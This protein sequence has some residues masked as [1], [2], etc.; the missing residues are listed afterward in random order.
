MLTTG[1]RINKQTGK[2][3]RKLSLAKRSGAEIRNVR[4]ELRGAGKEIGNEGVLAES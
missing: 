3:D 4:A 2:Q 1:E